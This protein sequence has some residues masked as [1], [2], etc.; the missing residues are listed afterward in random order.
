MPSHRLRR[1]RRCTPE[2]GAPSSLGNRPGSESSAGDHSSRKTDPRFLKG[3]LVPLDPVQRHLKV[4]IARDVG[5]SPVALIDQEPGRQI[6]AFTLSTQMQ[7]TSGSEKFRSTNTKGISLFRAARDETLLLD[8]ATDDHQ[9][10]DRAPRD[11]L[12]K[13][14]P[15][16]TFS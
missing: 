14:P 3:P 16:S 8:V 1:R 4:E 15:C 6:S 13:D 10:V 11:H 12:V 5:D 7:L 9:A 2:G